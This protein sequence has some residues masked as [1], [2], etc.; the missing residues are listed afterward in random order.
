MHTIQSQNG[1]LIKRH[2]ILI[3]VFSLLI[4]STLAPVK[5]AFASVLYVQTT[6]TGS[7]A[8]TS[9]G[10]TGKYPEFT[11]TGIAGGAEFGS[12][13]MLASASTTGSV[14]LNVYRN[15]PY[16]T[17][18]SATA[19]VTTVPTVV[20]WNFSQTATTT[21][22]GD[23]W[24]IAPYGLNVAPYNMQVWGYTSSTSMSTAW[25]QTVSS[26]SGLGCENKMASAY[27]QIATQNWTTPIN[28]LLPSDAGVLPECNLYDV[29][30][31]ISRAIA[32]AFYPSV[33]LSE[34]TQ[35]IASSTRDTIPF[36]YLWAFS[37]K[38]DEYASY[39]T[40]S[41][42]ISVELSPIL[43]FFGGT[44]FASTSVTVLSGAGLRTTLGTTMWTFIQQLFMACAWA[45]FLFYV[46][47]RSIHLL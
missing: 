29:S 22:T 35:A 32:W 27:I 2:A 4:A 7:V 34:R 13:S 33:S 36:G 19:T 46:Y 1:V 18:F 16:G 15:Y 25:T 21:Q 30:A 40:T 26:V 17:P 8:C 24:K 28:P 5:V 6:G 3:A 37:D 44:A 39:S 42:A 10:N 38:I 20:T 31:C 12:V 45:G 23:V 11:L 14:T 43:N 9:D 41:L 47:R